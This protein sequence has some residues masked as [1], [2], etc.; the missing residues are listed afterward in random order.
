MV[1][2]LNY[3]GELKETLKR[4]PKE[5]HEYINVFAPQ[6]YQ[7]PEHGP[8]DLAINLKPGT[9]L[10]RQK[11]RPMSREENNETI[12]QT[13]EWERLGRIQ[14]SRSESAVPVLHVPKEDG[15][16]RMCV[17]LRPIN[18][19]TVRD[20]NKS[21][22]QEQVKDCLLGAKYITKLDIKDGYHRLRIKAGD[23]WKTAFITPIGLYEWKVMCFGLANAPSTFQKYV[24]WSLRNY[25]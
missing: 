20:E 22:L 3:E 11:Q 14:K 23:E 7:L 24:N 1:E 25:L 17:D 15:S 10:P 2:N 8:N 13:L 4:L 19:V 18:A 21:P 9:R 5:Y 12:R 6:Y 16:K